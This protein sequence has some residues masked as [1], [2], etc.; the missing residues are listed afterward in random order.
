MPS[1]RIDAAFTAGQLLA[2]LQSRNVTV[3]LEDEQL[4][5]VAPAG[6]LTPELKQMLTVHKAA[7]Q[8]LLR[9]EAG[10]DPGEPAI[11]VLPRPGPKPT[12]APRKH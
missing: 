11:P 2:H 6:V 9:A 1:N 8:D 3:R 10:V 5:I 12:S 4:R 7:L